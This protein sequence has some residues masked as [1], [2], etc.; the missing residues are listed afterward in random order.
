MRASACC[1]RAV[2][3]P[4]EQDL[5]HPDIDVLFQKMGGKAVPQGVERHALADLGSI[6]CG[7]AGPIELARRHRL[8]AIAPWK[9]PAL[10]S[11][12]LP[13]GTQ[14]FEQMRRQHHVAVLAT[15]ALLDADE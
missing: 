6:C 7:V 1:S 2:C 15:L 10:R 4:S 9:Q 3:R 12:G 13:P 8:H 5:D 14:Q 11:R